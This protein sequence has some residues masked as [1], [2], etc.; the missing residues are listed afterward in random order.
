MT[1]GFKA[2][3]GLANKRT[4]LKTNR[5]NQAELISSKGSVHGQDS[6]PTYD[7]AQRVHP[8]QLPFGLIAEKA[9]ESQH[10]PELRSY[11]NSYVQQ[12]STRWG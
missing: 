10:T 2:R 12:A 11:L 9:Q 5:L 4:W 8:Q 3:R 6:G 1:S 7:K